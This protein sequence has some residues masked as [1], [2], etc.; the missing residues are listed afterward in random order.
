MK[1]T[2]FYA[3][4]VLA[5]ASC[6]DKQDY[7]ATGM[8]E[9]QEIILSAEA[10]GKILS[11][12]IAEGQTITQGETL[13]VIDTL[14]LHLQREAL[15]LQ[16]RAI[17][18]TK[19]DVNKQV[20]ALREQISKSEKELQRLERLHKADAATQKQVDDANS[21]LAVLRTQLDASLQSLTSTGA[22]IENNAAAIEVQ[23][24]QIDDRLAKCRVG[25]PADGTVLV[26]YQ[27]AGE[28]AVQGKPLCKIADLNQIYLRAYFTSEQMAN[29]A[30]GQQVTVVADFG[31]DEQVEYEGTITWIASDSE[32]TPK[33][34]QT[35]ATRSN[36]V[37]ATK[38]AVKNDGRLK[39]GFYGEVHL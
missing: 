5:L 11:F 34:I 29:I 31:G 18:Q 13:A 28:L 10:T 20:A 37:Y 24:R 26:K 22:S 32:F 2:F 6:A 35:R 27:Q 17:L 9:A 14:Q 36:L 33:G 7:D 25:A 21:A 23:V 8:F 15:V 16:Q 3:L 39:I 38:I 1:K 12:P 4:A 30:L 19:P